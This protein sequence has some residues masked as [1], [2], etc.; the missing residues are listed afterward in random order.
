[1]ER[2]KLLFPFKKVH[3]AMTLDSSQKSNWGLKLI[4]P[5]SID[6]KGDGITVG[7]VDTGIDINHPDLKDNIKSVYDP[8]YNDP[9][10]SD[11]VGH[12]T[13]CA[14]IVAAIDNDFGVVGIAPHAKLLIAKGMDNNGFGDW[15]KVAKSIRWCVQQGAD[16][17]NLSLGA[18][19]PPP[20]VVH[21]SIQYAALKGVIV[22]AA[23]GNDPAATSQNPTKMPVSYPARYNEVIAVAAVGED[24]TLA[25]FAA[26]DST[27]DALAPGVNIYSTWKDNNYAMLS[28]TSQASPMVAGCCALLK[29]KY[30]N[31]I[32]NYKDMLF[33]LNELMKNNVAHIA[34]GYDVGIPNFMNVKVQSMGESIE[35][36]QE[37]KDRIIESMDKT[38]S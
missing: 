5:G 30:K 38:L 33:K 27:I 9:N 26:I 16:I 10:A 34:P 12:G 21:D 6:T 20:Q 15:E 23:S 29:A 11:S 28:G 3:T 1:M 37:E 31:E 18:I 7:L 36:K 25:P 13:H 24:G 2:I 8:Y 35:M 17:I 19:E 22:V 14:G 32:K 4:N